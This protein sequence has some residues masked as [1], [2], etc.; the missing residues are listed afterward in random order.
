MGGRGWPLAPFAQEIAHYLYDSTRSI[1]STIGIGQSGHFPRIVAVTR[2]QIE[3]AF[4]QR[5]GDF[6]CAEARRID[7]RSPLPAR[8]EAAP[9]L[10]QIPGDGVRSAATISDHT[11]SPVVST[12]GSSPAA[13]TRVM[14]S[15]AVTI[16]R[17][18]SKP[19]ASWVTRS[20]VVPVLRI[21][22]LASSTLASRSTCIRLC[23][24][25]SPP[26]TFACRITGIRSSLVV[27]ACKAA[28]HRTPRLH[29]RA[30]AACGTLEFASKERAFC[31]SSAL[32]RTM[33]RYLS[34]FKAVSY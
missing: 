12:A 21:S 19:L 30:Y 34:A 7:L 33:R 26:L 15:F 10:T 32:P 16:P 6:P 13:M 5:S 9:V 17:G 2:P 14:M 24:A 22:L 1:G 25:I 8:A 29:P 23:L 4:G 11:M 18:K 20:S 27:M 31:I 3:F 28:A